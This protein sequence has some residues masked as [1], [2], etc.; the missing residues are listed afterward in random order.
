MSA[1]A[2]KKGILIWIPGFDWVEPTLTLATRRCAL[3]QKLH[4]SAK[5]KDSG[6]SERSHIHWISLPGIHLPNWEPVMCWHFLSDSRPNQHV[7][8]SWCLPLVLHIHCW[9]CLM[10]HSKRQVLAGWGKVLECMCSF[11]ESRC[12]P[13]SFSFLHPHI[14]ANVCVCTPR[15][16]LHGSMLSA[17]YYQPKNSEGEIFTFKGLQH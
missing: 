12:C 10:L 13:R 11:S 3:Q 5:S 1:R 14:H 7:T 8:G 15:E 16:F 17:L 2:E 6:S 4:P 9:T